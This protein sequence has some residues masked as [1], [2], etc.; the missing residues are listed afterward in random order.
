MR[1]LPRAKALGNYNMPSHKHFLSPYNFK[2]AL[3]FTQSTLC[4][5][6]QLSMPA[7]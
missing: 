7:E 1:L 2:H 5:K 3:I 4:A 6:L